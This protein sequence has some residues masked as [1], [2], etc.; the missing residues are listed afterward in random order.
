MRPERPQTVVLQRP[1]KHV[2]LAVTLR[3][4]LRSPR[5][6]LPIRSIGSG[7]MVGGRI[8]AVTGLTVQITKGGAH[9]WLFSSRG[10]VVLLTSYSYQA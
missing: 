2:R 8:F 9:R 10:I 4:S 5:Q 1:V 3:N 7:G 6:C